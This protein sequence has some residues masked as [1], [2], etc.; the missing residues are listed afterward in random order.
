MRTLFAIIL[1]LHLLIHLIGFGKSNSWLG[2]NNISETQG[3]LWLLVSVLLIITAGLFLFKKP[4]WIIA[5]IPAIIISQTL[6]FLNWEEARFG[7]IFNLIILLVILFSIAGWSFENKY[8]KDKIGAIKDSPK[9]TEVISEQ[10]LQHLPELVQNY[11]T[12]AGFIGN[13]K[14]R[15]VCIRFNGQMREQRKNWFK[16]RS[17]QLNSIERPSRFFFMKAIFK[18][19]PTKGYHRYD[20]KTASMTIKV[21]SL[22]SVIKLQ[23]R[24]LLISDMVTYLNDICLFAPGALI[25]NKF[26]WQV[27]DE[28]MVKVVFTNNAQSVSA[29]LEIDNTGKLVNFFTNDRYDINLQKRFMFSTPVGGYCNFNA[30]RL[31]SYGEAIWHYPQGDFVYGKFE[32]KDVSYNI[33][34]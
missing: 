34:A 10:D 16:F 8:K 27:I 30:Y 26:K 2:E 5:A 29:V 19:V 9:S 15:N 13:P 28:H 14:I 25:G 20:G 6:I 31:P 23:T 18:G 17:E 32:V 4:S 21:L 12:A 22:F 11:I 3:F 1:L 24:E 7:S 33:E